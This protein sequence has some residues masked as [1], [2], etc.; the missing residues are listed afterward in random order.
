MA[1]TAALNSALNFVSQQRVTIDNSITRLND[2]TGAATDQATQLT[3]VQTNL[4]QADIPSISTQLALAQSQQSALI[5]VIAA[6]G[7]GSLFDKL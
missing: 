3:A 5:N 2:A 7:Q 1:D 6:L 4:I